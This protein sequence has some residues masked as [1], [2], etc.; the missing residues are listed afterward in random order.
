MPSFAAPSVPDI[1]TLSLKDYHRLVQANH[2]SI[3]GFWGGGL[4]RGPAVPVA[5]LLL[6]VV[7]A[8][9]AF[10]LGWI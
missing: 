6:L 3:E 9:A 8:G 1:A 10:K 2:R 4:S 5:L 7:L